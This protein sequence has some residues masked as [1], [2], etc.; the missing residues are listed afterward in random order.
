MDTV[1]THGGDAVGA[2]V[3][4]RRA[5]AAAPRRV[6]GAGGV[7]PAAPACAWAEGGSAW[8]SGG[9][10]ETRALAERPAL[11]RLLEPATFGLALLALSVRRPPFMPS[12]G[13]RNRLTTLWWGSIGAR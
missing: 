5:E 10:D 13:R 8:L 2:V 9:G 7:E 6:T 4:G 12:R 3:G 11:E 1:G